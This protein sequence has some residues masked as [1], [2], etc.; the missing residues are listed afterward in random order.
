MCQEGNRTLIHYE[1]RL[2]EM[3]ATKM[4]PTIKRHAYRVN[5]DH[6]SI[7]T[8]VTEGF[9]RSVCFLCRDNFFDSYFLLQL[10]QKVMVEL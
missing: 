3:A 4:H 6:T 9:L 8:N 5:Q 10:Y 7:I 1:K 2:T